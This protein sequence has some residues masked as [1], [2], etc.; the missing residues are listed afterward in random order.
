MQTTISLQPRAVIDVDDPGDETQLSGPAAAR[1][2]DAVAGGGGG[3]GGGGSRRMRS[4]PARP[5]APAMDLPRHC[6]ATTRP[7]GWS[8][9]ARSPPPPPCAARPRADDDE[10]A[11]FRSQDA[12]NASL[13]ESSSSD[14]DLLAAAVAVSG[15]P[16]AAERE[17]IVIHIVTYADYRTPRASSTA[18]TTRSPSVARSAA[19]SLAACRTSA[20]AGA[21]GVLRVEHPH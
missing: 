1:R 4:P 17:V 11:Y 2:R 21:P 15:A 9:A 6:P 16:A 20:A 12:R 18:Q 14:D 13:H 19:M 5:P 8:P 10:L 7:R 3:G